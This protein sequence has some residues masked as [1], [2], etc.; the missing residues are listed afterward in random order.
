MNKVDP[1]V[2]ENKVKKIIDNTSLYQLIK[3]PQCV[4]KSL[5]THVIQS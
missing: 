1:C 3:S 5:G 4:D 2:D